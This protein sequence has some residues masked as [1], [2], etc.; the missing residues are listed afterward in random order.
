MSRSSGVPF[1]PLT[2]TRLLR[3]LLYS[4][5][6]GKSRVTLWTK[7]ESRTPS[8]FAV[9]V[10]CFIKS[11]LLLDERQALSVFASQIHLSQRER[12]CI[13]R[14]QYMLTE[15]HKGLSLWES[16]QSRRL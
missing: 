6:V 15:S 4:R 10:N 7:R 11:F 12:Q 9:A 16:W 1:L 8:S 14:V 5:L 2:L 13:S 3:K